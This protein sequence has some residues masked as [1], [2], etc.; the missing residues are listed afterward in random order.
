MD[1]AGHRWNTGDPEPTVDHC[2]EPP[3]TPPQC[4]ATTREYNGAVT[5]CYLGAGHPGE[6][7]DGCLTWSAA[8]A[9]SPD[10]YRV[11]VRTVDIAH[12]DICE[13][14]VECIDV[15]EALQLD[16]NLGNVLKYLWRHGK[17]PGADPVEDLEKARAYLDRAITAR[18][19]RAP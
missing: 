6:H 12:Y 14:D 15:I 10:Y 7:D 17:K 1:D 16:Y 5:R 3:E 19:A 2:A 8:P 13:F 18:K 4:E 11:H 9:T